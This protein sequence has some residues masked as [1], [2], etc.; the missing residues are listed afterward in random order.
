MIVRCGFW[1]RWLYGAGWRLPGLGKLS[2][3]RPVV[4]FLVQQA[5]RNRV[6][7][8]PIAL[9]HLRQLEALPPHHRDPFGRII[10]AQAL[11]EHLPLVSADR[12]LA[13]YGVE[14]I[15]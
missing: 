6:E 4:E 5:R 2:L 14:V 1:G 8:L 12:S 9:A 7:L 3:P 13:G 15:W 10:V 11:A